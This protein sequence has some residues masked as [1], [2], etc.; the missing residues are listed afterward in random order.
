[1]VELWP[2]FY[3]LLLLS[4]ALLGLSALLNHRLKI[5]A[6]FVFA[7]FATLLSFNM[8][9][10]LRGGVIF[11]SDASPDLHKFWFA[12]GLI[13]SVNATAKI[14]QWGFIKTVAGRRLLSIPPF[15]VNL[16]GWLAT[17]TAAFFIIRNVFDVELTSLLVSS[18]VVTAVIGLSLQ[19]V[20]TSLFVGII[21]QLEA[22]FVVG[23]WV[24]VHGHEGQIEYMSWRTLGLRTRLNNLVIFANSDI[25]VERI[26]NYS[27]PTIEQGIA[28]KITASYPNAPDKVKTALRAMMRGI[29]GVLQ[30]P[31]PL[32]L[33]TGFGGS[34]MLYEIRFRIADYAQRVLIED[35]VYTAAW[36]ALTRV[37]AGDP[38]GITDVNIISAETNA[39]FKADRNKRIFDTL[40]TIPLFTALS[41]EQIDLLTQSADLQQYAPTENLVYQ[42]DS[43]DS[44]FIILCG[45]AGVWLNVEDSGTTDTVRIDERGAGEFFGE[46]SLLTGEP[47][48]ATV[49]AD[50]EME[51]IVIDSTPMRVILS[52]DP[53]LVEKLVDAFDLNRSNLES[54]REAAEEEMSRRLSNR[55]SMIE[56]ISRFFG[57]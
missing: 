1:M 31:A 15:V 51:V 34:S 3:G 47:R 53:T 27:K 54:Q 30:E 44:L 9:F 10:A 16:F 48:T 45:K 29:D 50:S 26:I 6:Q 22:P 25:A 57:I 21:L 20:L 13:F 43:G 11:P 28:V 18:T 56:R 7:I 37:G 32:I 19:Q 12:L 55:K 36:Y 46:K 4:L 38:F 14:L 52:A 23:D 40:R 33:A 24:D 42:G 49:R 5:G 39:K 8:L 35:Q 17:F 41:D 2:G